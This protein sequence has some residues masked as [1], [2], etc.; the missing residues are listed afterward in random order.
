MSSLA[1]ELKAINLGQ[2]F[3]DFPM[4]GELITLVNEAMKAGF[5]QYVPMQ[6]YLPLREAIAEKINFLYNNSI[7][8]EEQ[9]TITPGGTYAIYTALTTVLQPG[10]EAIIFEPA[11]DSYIPGVIMNGAKPVLINLQFPEYKIDWG[12]VR[13]KVSAKT[14]VIMLNS[15]NN[16]TGTI[17]REEDIEE[18]RSIVAGT[19]IFIVSDE[20]YEHLIFDDLPHLSML[21]YPDLAERSFVCFRTPVFKQ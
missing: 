19:D 5:N 21:R 20:V 7:H 17:L 16:P 12:E 4:S 3:P 1:S 13:K 14:R 8:P 6:G 2:G 18:L 9:I 10:D 11:Y 15:P